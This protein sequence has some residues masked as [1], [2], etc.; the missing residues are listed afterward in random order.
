M[1]TPPPLRSSTQPDSASSLT[2][3]D[4]SRAEMFFKAKRS[5]LLRQSVNNIPEKFY[6]I[7][8]RIID[9]FKPTGQHYKPFYG[10]N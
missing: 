9:A 6:N 7:G 4:E 1:Y 5:S 8:C 3:N 2:L 10:R